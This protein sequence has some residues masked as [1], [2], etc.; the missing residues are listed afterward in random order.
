ML[1][2]EGFFLCLLRVILTRVGFLVLSTVSDGIYCLPRSY[3]HGPSFTIYNLENREMTKT[4]LS[5]I[6][7]E[8]GLVNQFRPKG[9]QDKIISSWLAPILPGIISQWSFKK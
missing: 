3:W 5:L 1:G 9:G 8:K 7:K 2:I 4:F 6:P